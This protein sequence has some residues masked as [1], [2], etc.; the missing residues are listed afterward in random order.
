MTDPQPISATAAADYLRRAAKGICSRHG[1]K[2]TQLLEYRAADLIERQSA[3]IERMRAALKQTRVVI[4]VDRESFV[5]CAAGP[6]PLDPDDQDIVD[7]YDALLRMI[8]HAMGGSDAS[9]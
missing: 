2:A 1:G 7:Q 4:A 9:K 3:Q 8:D 5:Q 6:D